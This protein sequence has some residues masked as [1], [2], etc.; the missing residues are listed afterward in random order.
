MFKRRRYSKPE[1]A[2]KSPV[3]RAPTTIK[4]NQTTARMRE[5]DTFTH[6][7]SIESAVVELS[8][9]RL[10]P[11]PMSRKE[12][13][14]A[15]FTPPPAKENAKPK[16][17]KFR[18]DISALTAS[19]ANK[20]PRNM[21]ALGSLSAFKTST[22]STVIIDTLNEDIQ[23]IV[24][25]PLDFVQ[26]DASVQRVFNRTFIRQEDSKDDATRNREEIQ[27]QAR[28]TFGRIYE[29]VDSDRRCSRMTTSSVFYPPETPVVKHKVLK[30]S[31]INPRLLLANLFAT[32]Q[33]C[34]TQLL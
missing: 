4:S 34:R 16:K 20:K 11:N 26:V 18:I 3:F 22:S 2:P 19:Q 32:S 7:P 30:A 17:K 28:R 1:K 6:E 5:L 27:Q 25:K 10:Q 9:R 31:P 8:A 23:Q 12:G 14:A 13:R 33:R 24:S 29:S 15:L 21:L